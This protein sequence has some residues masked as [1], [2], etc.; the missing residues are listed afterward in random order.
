V[1]QALRQKLFG[2]NKTVKPAGTTKSSGSQSNLEAKSRLTFCLSQDRTGLNSEEMT[3]FKK[4]LVGLIQRYFIV[5]EEKFGISYE[6]KADTTTLLINSPVM[7]RRDREK[8]E[9]REA[10]GEK[11]AEKGSVAVQG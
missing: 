6:R 10:R 8:K 9:G 7:V 5:D 1:F 2:D 11:I 3:K 4:E